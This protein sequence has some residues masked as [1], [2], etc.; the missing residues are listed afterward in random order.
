MT[1][2]EDYMDVQRIQEN[3]YTKLTENVYFNCRKN[4][5]KRPD[6]RESDFPDKKPLK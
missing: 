3:H 2:L 1:P 5:E 4:D 6:D